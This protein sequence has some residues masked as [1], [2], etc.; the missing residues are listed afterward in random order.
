M[1]ED[2][3][4][5]YEFSGFRLDVEER[6]L[7]RAGRRIAVPEK[8]FD[9]L[10]LLISRKGRLVAKDELMSRVWGTTVVEEN[11][12]DKSISR[13]RQLLGEKKGSRT[14]IETVRGHGYRF[15]DTVED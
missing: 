8:P 9:V 14:F 5:I 11:N 2:T 7:M 3:E 12:L 1:S 15:V 13:L 10:C 6:I 4:S